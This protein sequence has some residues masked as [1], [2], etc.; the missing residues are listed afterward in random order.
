MNSEK[1]SSRKPSDKDPVEPSE[2]T[3]F[4]E[5]ADQAEKPQ[6]V[7]TI[8]RSDESKGT[9]TAEPDEKPQLSEPAEES[10]DVQPVQ[11]ERVAPTTDP[12]VIQILIKHYTD[13]FWSGLTRTNVALLAWVGAMI[14]IFVDP[15]LFLPQQAKTQRNLV[16][17]LQRQQLDADKQSEKRILAQPVSL[18]TP[19]SFAPAQSSTQGLKEERVSNGRLNGPDNKEPQLTGERGFKNDLEEMKPEARSANLE[20]PLK[21]RKQPE[22]STEQSSKNDLEEKKQEATDPLSK[23][24]TPLGEISIRAIY[25]PLIWS[26]LFVGLLMFLLHKRLVLV[27]TLSKA[28]D[29]HMRH[30]PGKISAVSGLGAWSPFWLAPLPRPAQDSA[31]SEEIIRQFL[32][33]T[34]AQKWREK[35]TWACLVLGFL[36]Y[37]VVAWNSIQLIRFSNNPK[38]AFALS[39]IVIG[40][41]L[42]S[43]LFAR[44][45]FVPK[46]KF[47]TFP[48]SFVAH[49]PDRRRFLGMGIG[50]AG[51]SLIGGLVA[52]VLPR[53]PLMA[54]RIISR[55]PR[56]RRK[57]K[58]PR[59]EVVNK[60]VVNPSSG[61]ARD[62]PAKP[63]AASSQSGVIHYFGGNGFTSGRI[64][65]NISRTKR[66]IF[67]IEDKEIIPIL[68]Q[69]ANSGTLQGPRVDR[70]RVGALAE[71]LALS[72]PAAKQFPVLWSAI[73]SDTK[74][75]ENT[76]RKPG[77]RLYDLYAGVAYHL[78]NDS[79]RD[80][81]IAYANEHWGSL[82][83]MAARVKKWANPSEKWKKKWEDT[84]QWKSAIGD[85]KHPELYNGYCTRVTS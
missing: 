75:K 19:S 51:F 17:D 74:L 56:W 2:Q 20:T 32:G 66:R 26:V 84:P 3:E 24:R 64:Y 38:L 14:L 10:A 57:M 31:F 11:S 53:K 73:V 78:K 67:T 81:L 83:A 36:L 76:G 40:F 46:V 70:N 42:S 1:E 50:L 22:A 4:G 68:I 82:P 71:C 60:F 45:W 61:P 16:K 27:G 30:R 69:Q 49:S 79:E 62:V 80:K 28:I 72:L 85:P 47:G 9:E 44:A 33:W 12:D 63:P 41:F 8:A 5:A 6:L 59:F 52:V 34:S 48:E 23:L 39:I 13:Q 7:K 37:A 55:F 43:L 54:L 15:I 58:V 18:A 21:E 77:Y 29:L 25:A 65:L 35:L